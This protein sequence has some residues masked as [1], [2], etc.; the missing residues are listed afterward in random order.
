MPLLGASRAPVPGMSRL[1]LGPDEAAK[2]LGVSPDYF[3][4]HVGPELRIGRRGRRK[5]IPIIELER[6]LDRAA[7]LTL[8]G[9]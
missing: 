1:A 7:A 6:W 2:C 5:L 3:D 4:E 9:R 8:E